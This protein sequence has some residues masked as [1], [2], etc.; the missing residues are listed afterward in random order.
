MLAFSA[1]LSIPYQLVPR[2]IIGSAFAVLNIVC[3]VIS[4][5]ATLLVKKPK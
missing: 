3:M 5:A 4:G 2:K 1:L